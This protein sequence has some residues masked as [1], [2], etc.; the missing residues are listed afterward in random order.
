MFKHIIVDWCY[1]CIP[2][3][4]NLKPLINIMKNLTVLALILVVSGS[5]VA[6]TTNWKIDKSHSSIGFNV[7]HMVVSEATGNF[8]DFDATVVSKSADFTG[9]E[10]EFTAKVA[11]IN[12]ENEKRD[13]HLKSGDFFEAEKYPNVTFKGNLV[14]EGGKYLLKGKFTM[15]DVTKDVTFDVTYGGQIDTGRG[16]KAGFKLNGKINRQDYNL[17]WANKLQ[18]G[19]AVVGDE[20]EV[21]CKIEL[22]KQA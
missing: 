8:T 11:S 22:D 3:R 19:S 9:A 18:D 10:V 4:K 2:K 21:V 13:G 16:V 12:T 1:S 7:S 14:K 17:K 20:V 5:L 6:Q 15:K